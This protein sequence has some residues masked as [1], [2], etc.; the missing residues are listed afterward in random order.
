MISKPKV[1]HVKIFNISLQIETF[2]LL[3]P[4]MTDLACHL[5]IM[6]YIGNYRERWKSEKI[7]LISKH[8][9]IFWHN[10]QFSYTESV[11]LPFSQDY[12]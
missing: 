3:Y 11:P 6:A 12:V 5:E 10:I 1:F 8:F 4:W 2:W 9:I 7:Y